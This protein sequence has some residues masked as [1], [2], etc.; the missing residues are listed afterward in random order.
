MR[1]LWAAS[2]AM[3]VCLALGGVPALAQEPSGASVSAE[4]PWRPA[5]ELIDAAQVSAI[6]GV[7]VSPKF[8]GPRDVC[9]FEGTGREV[10]IAFWADSQLELYRGEEDRDLVI[11]GRHGSESNT[12]R[13]EWQPY[14]GAI[15]ALDDGGLLSADTNRGGDRKR[16]KLAT[17]VLEAILG[18][19]PVTTRPPSRGEPG[20]LGPEGP[21]CDHLP[22]DDLNEILG[23]TF[24]AADL[25]SSDER[26]Y[27]MT[28]DFY[29]VF[30]LDYDDMNAI[31]IGTYTSEELAV[32]GRPARW[33][34]VDN[35]YPSLDVDAGGDNLF[36]VR[37]QVEDRAAESL[38]DPAVAIAE[39][40]I[41]QLR[42]V[43]APPTLDCSTLT[44]EEVASATGLSITS[45]DGSTGDGCA[46]GVEG[47][48][49]SFLVSVIPE[50]I[51]ANYGLALPDPERTEVAGHAAAASSV[52]GG[53][54]LMVDIDGLPGMTGYVML[55]MGSDFPEDVDVLAAAK[56][57]A[58]VLMTKM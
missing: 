43:G 54:V 18:A 35:G 51:A 1:N 39:A 41:P 45:A 27:V 15:V 20:R 57:L 16:V 25:D 38:R 10:S 29:V 30:E 52:P 4:T 28:P 17:A 56:R 46:Y 19:G 49:S 53:A 22:L 40:V 7:D 12:G 13:P 44:V 33:D 5:C 34:P 21:M 9:V 6:V 36:S 24:T 55:V 58:E 26:C 32:A 47:G 8:E 3:V 23:T 2:A 42:T 50:E 37:F 31:D 11:A 48:A 14:V